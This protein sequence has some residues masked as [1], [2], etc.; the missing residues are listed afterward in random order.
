MILFMEK[1]H[2]TILEVLYIMESLLRA[3]VKDM[4][5]THSPIMMFMKASFIMIRCLG[6]GNTNQKVEADM[7]EILLKVKSM[8]KEQPS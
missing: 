3:N 4:E 1:E 7:K 8:A 5:Y 6:K 2:F